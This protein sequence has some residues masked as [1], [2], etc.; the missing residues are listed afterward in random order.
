MSAAGSVIRLDGY[1][2]EIESLARA[3]RDPGCRVEI[4]EEA[5]ERLRA[6][7][8]KIEAIVDRYKR[9]F[10]DPDA[11]PVQDYGVTTGFGEFK[12]IPVPPEQL[13]ELQR[14]LLLSHSVGIGTR[15][16]LEDRAGCF[17]A[18]VVRATLLIRINAFLRGH[19]G[20]REELVDVLAAMFERG[21]VPLVPA[22]GSLGSSGDLCPLCH[23]FTTLLGQGVYY[24][25]EDPAKLHPASSLAGHLGREIPPIGAKEGLALS[26]GATF[27][28]ALLAL[29]LAD[30]EHLAQVA[31]RAAALSLEAACGCA[32][33]FDPR[34]H[35]ARGQEGQIASAANIRALLAG[36]KLVDSAGA[37]QDAYSLRCAPVV[38]GAARDAIR[39]A[40]EV[41]AREINAATDNPLFFDTE[42][43]GGE[44][45][46]WQFAANWPAGYDGRARQ[47]FSAGNFHGE[48]VA[49]AAD[50][51]AIAVAELANIAERRVQL[52]LDQNH[53]RNLPAN[54]VARRGVQSGLMLLQYSAASLVSENKV[55]AHPASVDSIPTAANI[56]DHVAVATTA[57]YKLQ[58]VVSNVEAVLAIELIAAAQAIDWRA[59]MGYGPRRGATA[60]PVAASEGLEK[61]EQEAANFAAATRPEKRE[62]IAAHL[63]R[64]SRETYLAI[65]RAVEP[66]TKDRV[67]AGDVAAMREVLRR[68]PV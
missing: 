48:P 35:A 7:R 44:P 19:S 67:L 6:C 64:G 41:A 18:E 51:L 4:A 60:S 10:A 1:S 66:V 24:L 2:L 22:R 26:N 55:L 45:W 57:A 62:S 38:H 61:V 3:A 43:P 59:G 5:R 63:G 36:S 47:S 20:I 68:L 28:A 11:T 21:V 8:R 30:A 34:I 46:D 37:V 65:R 58:Q 15:E 17:S 16:G 40:R 54:L 29:A 25:L 32:R 52:L 56:E 14:N 53:N 27:S 50:V 49:M 9:D 23:L 33:A 12:D 42:A 13:E 39:Y 31:D